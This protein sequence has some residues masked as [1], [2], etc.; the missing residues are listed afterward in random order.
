MKTL[1]QAVA[2]SLGLFGAVQ[3][4]GQ[5]QTLNVMRS[6]EA[7]HFDA[8]RTSWGPTGEV[9]NLVQDTLVVLDW[10]AK[11]PLPNLAKSWT[12]S[13][14]GKLYTF[15]LRDDVQFC[16]GKKF[17]ADDVVFSFDRLK[18]LGNRA[19]FGW[20]AGPIKELRATGPH[21]VEY[22]LSEPFSELLLQLTMWTNVIHNKDVV[23]QLGTDYGVKGL[24]GTGP[25][26]FVA[27]QPRNDL[28]LRRH[29]AYRWGPSMYQNKGPV[30][31]Q[32][33]VVKILPEESSRLAA[34]LAGQFDYTNAFP[35][36]FI[37]QA[38]ANPN[39]RVQE[40][41][42]SFSF[43]YFGY[44][45]TRDMVAD[46]RVREAMN[47]A[48]NRVEMNAGIFLGEARPM[49]T[50]VNPVAKDYNPATMGIVKEDVERAKRLLDEAGWRM[51]ADGVR[52]KDGVK[53]APKVYFTIGNNSVKPAEAIQGYMRRIGIDWRLHGWDSA[54]SSLK[55]GEQDYEIWSVSVPYLSAGDVLNLYFD[56]KNIPT[57]NRFNW[58]DPRTDEL[59]GAGRRAL[60]DTDRTK[61]YM[62]AQ[63]VVMKAH[64]MMPV[65]DITVH[66]VTNK[67]LKGA[68]PHMLYNSTI[69]KALDLHH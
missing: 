1:L 11:T 46:V 39:L 12:I 19:P 18:K 30:K 52:E 16:S 45:T 22:E 25:W 20:R 56:S 9:A 47:I 28:V 14:D 27:W 24:D 68:R 43:L 2:L 41:Q 59:L 35:R 49:Y 54:I 51:G 33:M 6:L 61:A 38:K 5:A 3:A 60:T 53:L 36:Q 50:Y 58:R 65:L 63:E 23:E 67:R 40:S 37:A 31:F 42:G 55:M 44:K 8:H 69:Y 66:E 64:L 17:T 62:D 29:D 13:P 4:P 21:T 57:P 7:P 26:C 10:D 32:R 34:M 15:Q 48:I